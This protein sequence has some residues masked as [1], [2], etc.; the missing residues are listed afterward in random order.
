[1]FDYKA[2]IKRAVLFVQ[3]LGEPDKLSDELQYKCIFE[4]TLINIDFESISSANDK[5]IPSELKEFWIAGSQKFSCVN[6]DL[7][8]V[9]DT[10]SHTIFSFDFEFYGN[11]RFITPQELSVHLSNCHEWAEETWITEYPLEKSYWQNSI[12]FMEMNNGDYL[13]VDITQSKDDPAVVYLSHDDE[14]LIIAETF[15]SFLHHWEKIDY[16]GPEIWII[17]EFLDENKH[18]N[19][20]L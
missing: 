2:W 3:N 1:M 14:S 11:A 4:S 16:A 8:L 10:K 7:E 5:T 19:S 20:N 15:T 6:K 12:P 17:E 13:A 18:I 9:S